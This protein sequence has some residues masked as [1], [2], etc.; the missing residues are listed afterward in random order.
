MLLIV[1]PKAT[2]VSNRLKNLVVYA[3]RAR[4]QLEAVETQS[5]GHATALTREAVLGGY[6]VVV[7]FGGDG[8]V[9]EAAN[10]LAGSN[11]P[12]SLLPGGCTNV[13]C[14]TLGMPTDVVDA[15][16]H[17]LALADDFEPRRIDLGRINDRYFVMSCG[18]GLD[19]ETARWVDQ[20]GPLK[21]RAG[22]F[23]FT[24]AA[25]TGFHTKYAGRKP[26]IAVEAGSERIEGVTAIVQNSD[27]YTY[28]DS[29][30]VRVCDNPG[31]DDGFLSMAV[32]EEARRRDVP[33]LAWR[34]L[35]GK[36][37]VTGHSRLRSLTEIRTARVTT[38]D[39]DGEPSRFPVQ[40]DGDYVGDHG[41]AR[42]DI[43]PGSLLV[44]S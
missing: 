4:Y 33:E 37:H 25:L 35:A 40:V 5:R 20:H 2:T 43:S 14:R 7:A 38:L 19:A 12:L 44:V 23:F 3:L 22:P 17:L 13:L 36:P 1:N 16:E 24:F 21:S 8:T 30:P 6:D 9:N 31:L 28:F 15:T 41:E 26:W 11:V 32:L 27:P 29:R 34:L 18:I 39:K 10:G 42:F